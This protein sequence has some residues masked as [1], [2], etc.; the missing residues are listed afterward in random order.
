MQTPNPE[1]K[2]ILEAALMAAGEPLS[3]ERMQTLFVEEETPPSLEELQGSL[4]V[5]AEEYKQRGITLQEVASGFVI[6]VRHEYSGWIQRLWQER[7]PRYSRALLETLAI[8]VYK[9]PVTRGILKLFEGWPSRK[10]F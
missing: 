4:Q 2:N 9:Q 7:P 6:Q 3:L 8:V 5:L 1:V 10:I